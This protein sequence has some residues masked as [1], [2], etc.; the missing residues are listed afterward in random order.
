MST[1]KLDGKSKTALLH[2][3]YTCSTHDTFGNCQRPV[4]SLDVSLYTHEI[5][6]SLE[7]CTQLVIEVARE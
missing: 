2:D 5:K 7:I 3:H 6:K 4:L 1:T